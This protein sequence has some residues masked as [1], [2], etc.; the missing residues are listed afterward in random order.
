MKNFSDKIREARVLLG[1][2]QQQLS[3]LIGVSK[4]SIAAYEAEGIQP[5]PNI[6]RTFADVLH[7]SI[8]YLI[9]DD[10]Q[11]P[12]YGIEKKD[13]VEE[14]RERYGDKAAK[15]MDFLLERNAALFAGGTLSQEAKDAF[16]EA[17]MRAYLACK[18]EARKTY[19]RK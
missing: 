3:E 8:E 2:N 17:V 15:E 6:L 13:Y 11:D 12:T 10:I 19:G 16:F 7:V 4:R 9:S 5:R 18:E 1:L 14:T